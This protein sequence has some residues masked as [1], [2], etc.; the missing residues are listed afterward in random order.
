MRLEKS[1]LVNI[2]KIIIFVIQAVLETVARVKP[3]KNETKEDKYVVC[4]V[5]KNLVIA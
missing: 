2:L 5:V 4:F 1:F 3:K